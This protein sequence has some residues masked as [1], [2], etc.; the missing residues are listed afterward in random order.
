MVSETVDRAM[1][2]AALGSGLVDGLATPAMIA[3]M[4]AAA[5]KAIADD[6]PKGFSTVGTQINVSHVAPTPVGMKVTARAVLEQVDG[7]R[8]RFAI[9]AEDEAGP[10]GKGTHERVII[11]LARFDDRLRTRSPGGAPGA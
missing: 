9:S 11:E 10:I 2:A 7:R 1:T 8:L 6:L 3:L 5:L 4:E